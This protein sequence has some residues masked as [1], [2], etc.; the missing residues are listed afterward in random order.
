MPVVFI[1]AAAKN[2]GLAIAEKYA[3]EGCDV[4]VSSRRAAD[5]EKAAAS[6]H[7]T[8]GVK[9]A[10]Y[11]LELTDIAAIEKT[12]AAVSRDFG[13]LDTFVACAADLGIGTDF[14]SVE[15]EAYDK[16][17][18]CNLKGTFFCAKYASLLMKEQRHG[19]LVFLSSVHSHACVSG[20]SL[21]SASKG[22]INALMRAL[23][24]ELGE[25][26]IR[27]N[28]VI[29]GAIKTDRWNGLTP[30]QIAE[31]RANWPLALES[32]GKDIA[33]AV[34]Y[35]GSDQSKTVTGAELVVD[36]GILASLLPG[37]GKQ[38]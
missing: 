22:G 24:V 30:E 9:S 33:N 8:Y 25:Y 4:A 18:D 17:L 13:R 12:F 31:K 20:R 38:S 1:T 3:S 23:A 34:Y 2:T 19:A 10:G 35:L 29:A 11:P 36:S 14:L 27:A 15:E 21:Y 37:K 16:V 7:E 32:T 6:L 5:A 28:C 26:G